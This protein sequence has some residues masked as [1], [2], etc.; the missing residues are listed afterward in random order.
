MLLGPHRLLVSHQ[1]PQGRLEPN[2]LLAKERGVVAFGT[3]IGVVPSKSDS[4]Y[5]ACEWPRS[6][7]RR[8]LLRNH[9]TFPLLIRTGVGANEIEE[10]VT[11]ADRAITQY[12]DAIVATFD[13]VLYFNPNRVESVSNHARA[14]RI[15]E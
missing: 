6:Q 15:P 1:E 8:V 9:F 2:A 4:G 12:D 5:F 10:R 3:V 14:R 7:S 11:A 13:A